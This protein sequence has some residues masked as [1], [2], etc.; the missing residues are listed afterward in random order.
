MGYGYIQHSGGST[1]AMKFPADTKAYNYV[2]DA[3][4]KIYGKRPLQVATGYS[5]GALI[6]ILKRL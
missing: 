6:D 1:S 5:V 2:S 3:L 4:A